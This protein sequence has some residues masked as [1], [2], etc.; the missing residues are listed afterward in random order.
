MVHF[1]NTPVIAL[2]MFIAFLMHL[3]M[4]VSPQ[5]YWSIFQKWKCENGV[6]SESYLF[7]VR[8]RGVVG[9]VISAGIFLFFVIG[10][11]LTQ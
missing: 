11:Y 9:A 8:V 3:A 10:S 2:M 6:P 1:H 5:T 4:I 7:M